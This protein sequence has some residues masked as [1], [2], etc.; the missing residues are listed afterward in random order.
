MLYK[1][2]MIS[3]PVIT[4][5]SSWYLYYTTPYGVDPAE[6]SIAGNGTGG[7][8]WRVSRRGGLTDVANFDGLVTI[9]KINKE[10]NVLLTKAVGADTSSNITILNNGSVDAAGS[11]LLK[12]FWSA[13]GTGVQRFDNT[14]T[15]TRIADTWS[16]AVTNVGCIDSS[17]NMYVAGAFYDAGASNYYRTF[18]GKY[19]SSNAL[20][21]LVKVGETFISGDHACTD[22]KVD[23]N[24]NVYVCGTSGVAKFNSS[25]VKQWHMRYSFR[26]GIMEFG[27]YD[28]TSIIVTGQTSVFGGCVVAKISAFGGYFIWQKV[29]TETQSGDVD[30]RGPQNVCVSNLE[31]PGGPHHI[32]IGGSTSVYTGTY[33]GY[34]SRFDTDGNHWWSRYHGNFYG[35]N[36]WLDNKNSLYI[37]GRS[38]NSSSGQAYILKVPGDTGGTLG[39]Y[40]STAYEIL[41]AAANTSNYTETEDMTVASNYLNPTGSTQ[42]SISAVSNLSVTKI[43]I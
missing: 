12:S 28:H 37:C 9:N 25:G 16:Q 32:F 35:Y 31:V 39:T 2:I 7:I 21:W 10:G 29:L 6:S 40:G 36:I 27:N 24:G 30:I 8:Y 4:P 43:L 22:V 41:P 42:A 17:G 34:A 18:V 13:F 38:G 3:N 14:L 1:K 5:E 20:V 19:N 11:L 26:P 33:R 23:K 15:S